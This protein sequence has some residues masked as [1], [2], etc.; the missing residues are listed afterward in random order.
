MTRLKMAAAI[1]GAYI[2]QYANAMG[3]PRFIGDYV[4]ARAAIFFIWSL[5]PT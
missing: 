1:F 2:I 4:A 3:L 5:I